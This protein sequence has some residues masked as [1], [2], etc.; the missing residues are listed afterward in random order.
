[1]LLYTIRAKGEGKR[2]WKYLT[3]FIDANLPQS[4]EREAG[5]DASNYGTPSGYMTMRR[6]ELSLD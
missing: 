2:K 1:L 3:F 5:Q 4:I 6:I